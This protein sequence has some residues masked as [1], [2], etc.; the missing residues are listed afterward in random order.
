MRLYLMRH[1][2]A[3]DREDPA[4]P[5]DEERYLTPEGIRKTRDAA[6][7]L[8]SLKLSPEV[9]LT[10]PYVRAVQT[11]EIVAETFAFPLKDI[12]RSQA[13]APSA[14][15]SQLFKELSRLKADSVLCF[16]HAPQLDLV[17][18]QAIGVGS[19]VTALKKSGVAGLELQSFSPARG[20]IVAL[21]TPKIL[22]RLGG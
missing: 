17:I 2:L 21:V 22:R 6:K 7:G 8:T 5:P 18:A 16:G 19:P 4:C 15:P 12:V 1:G 9:L 10:S 13:L 11:A 20:F 3:I 14:R